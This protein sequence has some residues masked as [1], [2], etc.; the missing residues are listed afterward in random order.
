MY[1]VQ[2]VFLLRADA[3]AKFPGVNVWHDDLGRARAVARWLADRTLAH[4]LVIVRPSGVRV[5]V[6]EEV[7]L[8]PWRERWLRAHREGQAARQRAR[9]PRLAAAGR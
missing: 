9:E 2:E 1:A 8:A 7:P 5:E 3:R 6:V 4:R